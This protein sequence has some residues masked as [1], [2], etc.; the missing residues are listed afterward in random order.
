MTREKTV[1]GFLPGARPFCV[2]CNAP[3]TKK[4]IRVYDVDAQH[5]QGSYD[6]RGHGCDSRSKFPLPFNGAIR[7]GNSTNPL[8]RL[9]LAQLPLPP[10]PKNAFDITA[11]FAL[12]V[13]PYRLVRP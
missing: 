5:G 1:V 6:W 7:V 2:F 13:L 4:M 10:A 12:R 11:F 8:C 9:S 3:W